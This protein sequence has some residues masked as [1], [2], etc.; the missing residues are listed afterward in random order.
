M[1]VLEA[2]VRSFSHTN[3]TLL[4]TT[5]STPAF[6]AAAFPKLVVDLPS[7]YKLITDNL[8]SVSSRHLMLLTKN[9]AALWLLSECKVV[10]L[11]KTKVIIGSEFSDDRSE[12][13]VIQQLNEVK[14]AMAT[15]RCLVLMNCDN[16]YEALYD[17]LNQRYLLKKVR[18]YYSFSFNPLKNITSLTLLPRILK[19]EK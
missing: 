4:F 2:M 11:A 1:N 18:D 9:E 6:R 10:D 7:L 19:Q 5:S 16:M 15:G 12:L 17:I 13:Y 14:L 3:R 8:T